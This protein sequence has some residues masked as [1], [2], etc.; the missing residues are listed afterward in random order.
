MTTQTRKQAQPLF[1]LGK[2]AA[3]PGALDALK[4]LNIAPQK[5]LERHHGGDWGNITPE[6]KKANQDA[7]NSGRRIFS[8]YQY[9]GVSFWIITEADRAATTLLLPEEY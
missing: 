5:L 9:S 7:L 8:A 6:D 1:A 4:I 3:T 2:T